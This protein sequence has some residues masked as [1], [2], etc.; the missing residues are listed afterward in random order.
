[1]KACYHGIPTQTAV[2]VLAGSVVCL[3]GKVGQC[4][5]ENPHEQQWG[6]L[7]GHCSQHIGCPVPYLKHHCTGPFL[8]TNLT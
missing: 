1:M 5:V 6:G 7:V 8:V 2:A 3:P 4:N